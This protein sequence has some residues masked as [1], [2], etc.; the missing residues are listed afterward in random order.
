MSRWIARALLR[1]PCLALLASS[2]WPAMEAAA[3]TAAQA[4]PLKQEPATLYQSYCSV[5]HGDH[6]NGLSRARASLNPPPSDFTHPATKAILSRERMMRSVREGR[7]G[8]AMIG[9]KA[10][11]SDAQIAGIVDYVREN[12]M[13]LGKQP[14]PNEMAHLPVSA[15]MQPATSAR[16][17]TATSNA[18]AAQKM[19]KGDMAAGRQL[20]EQNCVACHGK[21][22]D[23]NGPRAYFIMPRPR[24]FVSA[25]SRTA[26]NKTALTHA[27]AQG[28]RG[29]EMPSWEKVLSNQ[30]IADVAE[31]VFRRFIAVDGGGG[32]PE[33]Q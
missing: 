2:G 20:Y 5:C 25:D 6:G 21:G 7:P 13:S 30:Q 12:F 24:S 32:Q 4:G 18:M 16:V 1:L 17:A 9:W 8:T 33:K 28:K 14:A 3:G 26:F 11:L 27:I 23:G 15:P 10:Q 29:T 22:G 19:L 31:F